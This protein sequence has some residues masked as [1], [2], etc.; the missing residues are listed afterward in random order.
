M[1]DSKW[2]RW[3][4]NI[5]ETLPEEISCS[6]CFDMVSVYV[7]MEVAGQPAGKML[8]QFKHHINQ[9][10]I[11]R[12]EYEL[13]RDLASAEVAGTGPSIDELRQEIKGES[14]QR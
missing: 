10:P 2:Q 6:E 14:S 1:Q 7:D 9:C 3:L 8:P 4:K 13:L 11:C 12:Q 5:H